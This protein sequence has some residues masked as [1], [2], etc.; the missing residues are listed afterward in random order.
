MD[1]IILNNLNLTSSW[2]YF[3]T[4]SDDINIQLDY[5]NILN[6]SINIDSITNYHG[7]IQNGSITSESFNNNAKSNITI[8]YLG[9]SVFN[10]S[11]LD[12]TATCFEDGWLGQT[13]WGNGST[14]CS[15]T[16]CYSTCNIYANSGGIL[17]SNSTISKCY[18]SG[19]IGYYDGGICGSNCS[20]SVTNSYSSGTVSSTGAGGIINNSSTTTTTNVYIVNG[21]W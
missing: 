10:S 7:F 1:V 15:I 2:H 11:T 17:G 9:I 8:S 12:N 14:G 4:T 13:Y 5:T 16:K 6:I 3:I 19:T 18:S 20:C 21:N